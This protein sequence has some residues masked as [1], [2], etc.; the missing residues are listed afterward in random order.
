MAS[1]EH[2]L[3][4]EKLKEAVHFIASSCP[5]EELGNVK[6]HKILYFSDMLHFVQE[7]TPL[8]GV[9]YVKQ[10]FGPVALFLNWA[11]ESLK[12]EGKLAVSETEYFGFYKKNYQPLSKFTPIYLSENELILISEVAEFVRGKS[13]REIS[14]ISHNSAWE[15]VDLGQVIPYATALRLV[16]TETNESDRQW[17]INSAREYAAQPLP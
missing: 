1:Q 7:G 2:Q 16:P 4:R 13:A 6:M 5:P 3:N 14:T 11:V 9:E 15:A 12:T 10:Q 17:A 8:T